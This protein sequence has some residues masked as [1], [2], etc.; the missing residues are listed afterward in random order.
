MKPY[1]GANGSF[2]YYED[3]NNNYNYEKG[4]SATFSLSW[5]KYPNLHQPQKY[6]VLKLN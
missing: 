5:N 6:R 2:K 1:T 4:S 3:E